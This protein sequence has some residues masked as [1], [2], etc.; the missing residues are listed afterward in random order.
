MATDNKY[1]AH[2]VPVIGVSMGKEVREIGGRS[3]RKIG[4]MKGLCSLL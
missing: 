2:S 4:G 1:S 3:Q